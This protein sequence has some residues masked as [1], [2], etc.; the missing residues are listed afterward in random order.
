MVEAKNAADAM[1]YTA[2]KA[3]RESGDKIPDDIKK[4]IEAKVEALKKAKEGDNIEAIKRSS[5]DLAVASQKIGELLYKQ[6]G[7]GSGQPEAGSGD[8]VKE[9]EFEEKKDDEEKK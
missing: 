2:E 9:A 8:S 3:L 4:D 6:G 5:Q 1:V 7:A